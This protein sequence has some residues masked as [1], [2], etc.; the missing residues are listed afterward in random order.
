MG[1]ERRE[2]LFSRLEYVKAGLEGISPFLMGIRERTRA[3][4]NSKMSAQEKRNGLQGTTRKLKR[5]QTKDETR[6]RL[7]PHNTE[8]GS[9]LPSGQSE[10]PLTDSETPMIDLHLLVLG[11]EVGDNGFETNAMCCQCQAADYIGDAES[12]VS[13]CTAAI[14]DHGENRE[15]L[16]KENIEKEEIL[17]REQELKA[18]EQCAEQAQMEE[19]AVTQ[20]KKA[21]FA[22]KPLQ[23]IPVGHTTLKNV[24]SHELRGGILYSNCG[25]TRRNGLQSDC[26]RFLCRGRPECLTYPPMCSHSVGLRYTSTVCDPPCCSEAE[27][28]RCC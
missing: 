3:A 9:I 14:L 28:D 17:P 23:K 27:M 25:C 18:R 11:A 13:S 7:L 26:G 5:H 16:E 2:R 4:E 22:G 12:S 6:S 1:E 21:S 15:R 8:H 19:A 10:F 20:A 24:N